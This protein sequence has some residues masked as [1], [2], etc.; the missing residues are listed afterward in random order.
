MCVQDRCRR[1]HKEQTGIF[2]ASF[3]RMNVDLFW[4][5]KFFRKDFVGWKISGW[6]LLLVGVNSERLHVAAYSATTN[7]DV[8]VFG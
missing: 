6:S 1:S 7:V 5:R 3:G 8:V 2:T 4:R